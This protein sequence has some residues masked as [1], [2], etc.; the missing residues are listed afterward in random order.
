[1]NFEKLFLLS[2]VMVVLHSGCKNKKEHV[3]PD[4]ENGTLY[5]HL[6][7]NIDMNEVEAYDTIYTNSEGRKI[8]LS[9]AQ[10]YISN[11]ELVKSDGSLYSI[12]D[13]IILK[14]QDEETYLIA[15][16]PVGNYKSVHFNVG[17]SAAQNKKTPSASSNDPLNHP[18]MWFGST[19]Q[20]DSFVFMNLQGKIDTTAAANASEA[21]MQPF[22]YKLGTDANY[23]KVVMPDQNYTI[24][25]NQPQYIHLYYDVSKIFNGVQLND[26]GNL[27]VTTPQDNATTLAAQLR[28][29]IPA[30]FSY[31]EH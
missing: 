1:M 17:L 7:T 10:L 26:H 21:Q 16:V 9:M 30:M 24:L 27:S 14:T 28:N 13:T 4:P 20:P 2:I 12:P 23:K 22:V 15:D 29:N 8:S 31:A 25:A 11:I 3:H 6:H 19:A 18:E 5:M